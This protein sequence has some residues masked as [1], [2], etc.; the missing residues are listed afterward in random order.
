MLRQDAVEP[1]LKPG[2]SSRMCLPLR[3]LPL[4]PA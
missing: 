1:L 3:D 4:I 2:E